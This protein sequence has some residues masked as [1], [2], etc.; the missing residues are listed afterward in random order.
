[1]WRHNSLW[2][3]SSLRPYL[4][5]IH[6]NITILFDAYHLCSRKNTWQKH[7]SIYY[8]C[9]F[10]FYFLP[11]LVS[12]NIALMAR[13]FVVVVVVSSIQSLSLPSKLTSFVLIADVP[14][15]SESRL[16]IPSVLLGQFCGF[17]QSLQTNNW[18]NYTTKVSFQ[19]LAY[20]TFDGIQCPNRQAYSK[21]VLILVTYS[22]LEYEEKTWWPQ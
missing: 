20:S 15:Q 21:D 13:W 1:M 4:P 8:H 7:A 6:G 22:V 9:L 17:T 11:Q 2:T 3:F 14:C 19:I 12:D 16:M 18:C 5:S 10:A